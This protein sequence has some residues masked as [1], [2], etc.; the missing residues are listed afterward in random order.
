M[1]KQ[2]GTTIIPVDFADIE[3]TNPPLPAP[4][5]LRKPSEKAD[6]AATLIAALL[7]KD[8]TVVVGGVSLI[9]SDEIVVPII[10]VVHSHNGMLRGWALP[11]GHPSM[12]LGFH[13][14]DVANGMPPVVM[15][16]AEVH[17]IGTADVSMTLPDANVGNLLEIAQF[18]LP[19]ITKEGTPV[20]TDW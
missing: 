20:V 2:N 3:Q 4:V 7:K 5:T 13:Y 12:E 9:G 19:F 17:F 14:I 6:N 1:K 15:A 8:Q 18:V 10:S 11:I 16:D